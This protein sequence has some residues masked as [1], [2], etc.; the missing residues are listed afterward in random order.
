MGKIRP[1]AAAKAVEAT[2]RKQSF[3]VKL[4]YKQNTVNK[5]ISWFCTFKSKVKI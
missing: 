1:E 5:K 3:P 2:V 4:Y